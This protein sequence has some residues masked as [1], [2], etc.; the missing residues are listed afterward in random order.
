MSN[1]IY[2]NYDK[3]QGVTMFLS[4]RWSFSVAVAAVLVLFFAMAIQPAEAK[5][6]GGGGSFGFSKKVA[7]KQTAPAKQQTA[8][9]K[10]QAAPTSTASTAAAKPAA[11][12]GASKWLGPLAGIAAG[13]LLAAMIFGDGFEGIQIMDILLFVLIAGLL[14]MFLMKRRAAQAQTAEGYPHSESYQTPQAE[15]KPQA[16]YRE[17][18]PEHSAYDPNSG[19]SI[20][21]SGLSGEAPSADAQAVEY[22]PSWFDAEGFVQGARMHFIKLQEIWDAADVTQ[23]REYC[24]PELASDLERELQGVGAGSNM[25]RVDEV[26][27]EIVAQ[28]IENGWFYVSIRYSGFI[29]EEANDGA[30]AFQEIWHIRR[31]EAGNGNW[32]VAGIQQIA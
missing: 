15:S 27:A 25:T 6:L 12:S 28:S 7:P 17:S 14:M 10:E 21:G 24:T 32:Q 5:R 22:A 11:A 31:D 30:H 13:G 2:F 3:K 4:Q 9:A 29:E 16:Q 20:I 19:G 8:P 1:K 18:M 23:L 26:D